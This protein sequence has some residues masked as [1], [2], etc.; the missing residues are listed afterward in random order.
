MSHDGQLDLLACALVASSGAASSTMMLSLANHFGLPHGLDIPEE[1]LATELTKVALLPLRTLAPLG[2]HVPH[3]HEAVVRAAHQL[4][5]QRQVDE[6]LH[7][8]LVPLQVVRRALLAA[9]VPANDR[10][11][12]T[13]REQILLLGVPR[14]TRYGAFVS[15]QIRLEL[16]AR[17]GE[18]EERYVAA[19]VS[20]KAMLR[21]RVV[22]F[23]TSLQSIQLMTIKQT[24]FENLTNAMAVVG[25]LAE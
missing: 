25:E 12:V 1:G 22:S 2:L 17:V 13:S 6:G 19:L 14:Q 23:T 18:L 4:S 15:V 20:N 21:G 16:T 11:V 10:L 7:A 8:V 3:D 5:I 24:L 9:D